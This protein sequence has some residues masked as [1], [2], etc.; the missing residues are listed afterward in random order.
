ME[1]T[2]KHADPEARVWHAYGDAGPPCQEKGR[3]GP[4]G[5]R[6]GKDPATRAAAGDWYFLA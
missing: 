5:K 4:G 6:V 2:K 1:T 3:F